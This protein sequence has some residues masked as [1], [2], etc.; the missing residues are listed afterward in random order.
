[1]SNGVLR[2][3]SWVGAASALTRCQFGPR[4]IVACYRAAVSHP[5][6]LRVNLL[7]FS[8]L[9]EG[10]CCKQRAWR[11]CSISVSNRICCICKF[12]QGCKNFTNDIKYPYYKFIS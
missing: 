1:M 9:A 8:T 4:Q 6:E 11:V 12:F 7:R 2:G 3:E 5:T 10:L